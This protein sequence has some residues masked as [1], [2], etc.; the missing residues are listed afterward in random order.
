MHRLWLIGMG[1]VLGV[2]LTVV[3]V[4]AQEPPRGDLG[5][6]LFR[7]EE[8]TPVANA[9]LVARHTVTGAVFQD[10]ADDR[11][12][13]LM[14]NVLAGDYE[15]RAIDVGITYTY[16]AAV[17]V[18]PKALTRIC[19]AKVP[20]QQALKLLEMTCETKPIFWPKY[21]R[22]VIGGVAAAAAT[23]G[24]VIA[25]TRKPVTPPRP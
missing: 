20:P 12:R 9:T 10:A 7:E 24:I 17:R 6:Q 5:G 25:V 15:V 14:R 11:G 2:L 4:S 16:T 8:R 13:F 22:Y 1:R 18:R 3:P 21:G 19:L 23:T